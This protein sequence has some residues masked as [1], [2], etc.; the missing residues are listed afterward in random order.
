MSILVHL[1]SNLQKYT[2]NQPV[3]EA[4]GTTVGQCL[5]NLVQKYPSLGSRLFDKKQK[6]IS[7]VFISINLKSTRSAPLEQSI[8]KDDQIYIILIVAGG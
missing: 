3:V 6:L 5:N 1:Y 4:Q 8:E 2:E 7:N